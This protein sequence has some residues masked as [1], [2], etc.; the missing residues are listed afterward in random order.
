MHGGVAPETEEAAWPGYRGGSLTESWVHGG[1]P[2]PGA[3]RRVQPRMPTTEGTALGTG[4]QP[5]IQ[6][7][8]TLDIGLPVFLLQVLLLMRVLILSNEVSLL[9]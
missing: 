7:G 6:G 5:W 3:R 2:G 8:A 4:G 1:G 9:V